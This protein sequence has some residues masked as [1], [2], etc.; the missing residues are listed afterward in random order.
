MTIT[1]KNLKEEQE[2]FH[3]RHLILRQLRDKIRSHER[4]NVGKSN[5]EIRRANSGLYHLVFLC[6]DKNMR[7]SVAYFSSLKRFRGFRVFYPYPRKG[8]LKRIHTAQDSNQGSNRA[9]C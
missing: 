8:D 3:K 2:I 1:G 6:A 5:V 9:G 4:F 7:V